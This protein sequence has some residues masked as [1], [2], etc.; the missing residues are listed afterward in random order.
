MIRPTAP[1]P[2]VDQGLVKAPQRNRLVDTDRHRRR[3]SDRG[4]AE[5]GAVPVRLGTDLEQ[6]QTAADQL[7]AAVRFSST[8]S[9]GQGSGPSALPFPPPSPIRRMSASLGRLSQGVTASQSNCNGPGSSHRL[10]GGRPPPG[11]S[12][13][14]L[15]HPMA[16]ADRAFEV[17]PRSTK[18]GSRFALFRGSLTATLV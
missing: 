12:A 15:V 9:L 10:S 3:P 7:D 2:G 5:T 8:R 11:G 14:Q 13:S 18:R 17:G 4:A 1:S 6:F 16:L